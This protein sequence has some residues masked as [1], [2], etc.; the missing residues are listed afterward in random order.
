MAIFNSYVKLLE[1]IDQPIFTYLHHFKDR[2]PRCS[3]LIVF[4]PFSQSRS[5]WDSD[6]VSSKMACCFDELQQVWDSLEG[7][8]MG[9]FGPRQ[10]LG[11][12]FQTRGVVHGA[13]ALD[14]NVGY[15]K[16]WEIHV[17]LPQSRSIYRWY[18]DSFWG[19]RHYPFS[20]SIGK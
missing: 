9:F 12:G 11:L 7:L 2:S 20:G 13:G 5:P 4:F 17:S 16:K 1:G 18:M 14:E 10:V 8:A 15:L 19:L 6:E 3:P